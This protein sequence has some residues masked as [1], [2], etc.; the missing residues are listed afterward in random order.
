MDHADSKGDHSVLRTAEKSFF[1]ATK[2][3]KLKLSSPC[4]FISSSVSECKIV[5]PSEYK[6]M[7]FT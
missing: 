7:I 5:P 3:L 1:K 4:G 6:E 2:R